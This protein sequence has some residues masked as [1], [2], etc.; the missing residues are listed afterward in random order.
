MIEVRTP[1]A[2][3][4]TVTPIKPS[5]AIRLGILLAPTPITGC[6][7]DG[8]GG[9]CALGAMALGFGYDGPQKHTDD[10]G[11]NES[12]P[13]VLVGDRLP[14]RLPVPSGTEYVYDKADAAGTIYALNDSEGW[15]RERIADWLEGLG[16]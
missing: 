3:V 7:F 13:Y 2:P 4:E 11:P 15:S 5:E 6:F 16:L 1:A 14:K 8:R 10:Q 12:D 9:A